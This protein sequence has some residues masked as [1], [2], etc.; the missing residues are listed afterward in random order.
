MGGLKRRR[1]AHTEPCRTPSVSCNV[2]GKS[3][4]G[5]KL[6]PVEADNAEARFGKP[7][8]LTIRQGLPPELSKRGSGPECGQC[9]ALEAR[10]AHTAGGG[11]TAKEPQMSDFFNISIFNC[12]PFFRLL[13][14][15]F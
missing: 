7:R 5:L 12:Y 9:V 1:R 15:I 6:P 3:L 14:F 4:P 11:G 13:K 2:R 8:P 10:G